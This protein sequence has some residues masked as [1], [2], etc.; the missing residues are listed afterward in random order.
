M[1]PYVLVWAG[2]GVLVGIAA[3]SFELLVYRLFAEHHLDWLR[4]GAPTVFGDPS[5]DY[6]RWIARWTLQR[7]VVFATPDWVRRDRLAALLLRI[8]RLSSLLSLVSVL[9]LPIGALL[10]S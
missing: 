6:K 5:R 4:L 1:N 2:V 9:G 3:L 10:L 7:E 8:F